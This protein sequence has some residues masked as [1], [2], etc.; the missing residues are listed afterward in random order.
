MKKLNLAIIGQGRSGKDIHGKYYVSDKNVYYNIKYVVELDEHRREVAKEMYPGCEVLSDYKELYTKNDIDLVVNDTYSNLHFSITKELLEHKFNVLCEKPFV[1][2]RYECDV[3]ENTAKENGVVLAVFQ[4]SLYSPMYEDALR[5]VNDKV[6]GEPLQISIRYN[7]FSRRWD[8]QTLQTRMA[9]NV[10]NTGPHPLGIALGLLNFDENWE[11]KFGSVQLTP[12]SSGDADDYCKAIIT[13][14]N[15]PIVDV[16]VNN[17]DAF[18]PYNIKI[19][20]TRG[21]F[22]ATNFDWKMKYIV[23][24]ENPEQPI[25]KDFLVNAKGNPAYCSEKL[26]AH[27][28]AGEYNGTAFDVGT[29]KLYEDLYFKITENRE[30]YVDINKAR[31]TVRLIEQLQSLS[32]AHVKYL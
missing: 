5:V 13:A 1:R 4:Q 29:A 12:L 2:N 30:M 31:H 22:Q 6:V 21:T 3:L 24:G 17:T 27:E 10:F 25:K 18:C 9:G 11:L 8:W 14:P 23:D 28:E 16:E 7:G 26:I 19:Q 15:K 32:K 20:G